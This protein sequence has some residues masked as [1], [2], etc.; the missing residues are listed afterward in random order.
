MQNVSTNKP[1][2]EVG[3]NVIIIITNQTWKEG[4]IIP[5][6]QQKFKNSTNFSIQLFSK[7]FL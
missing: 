5:L 6:I 7:V 2:A 3:I 4:R 1:D